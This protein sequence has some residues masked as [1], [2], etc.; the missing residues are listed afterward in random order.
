MLALFFDGR[1]IYHCRKRQSTY[2]R[3]TISSMSRSLVLLR[4]GMS[5]PCQSPACFG[6][7]SASHHVVRFAES[8]DLY[9]SKLV[10]ISRIMEALRSNVPSNNVLHPMYS[11]ASCLPSCW[12]KSTV[13]SFETRCRAK[14]NWDVGNGPYGRK[15]R[16]SVCDYVYDWTQRATSPMQI[17]TLE[18]LSA[19]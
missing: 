14:S 4:L 16:T 5:A 10:H 8:G 18:A 13:T 7:V 11:H 19:F 1:R 17:E 2:R 6:I 12:L 3:V 9:G 15:I